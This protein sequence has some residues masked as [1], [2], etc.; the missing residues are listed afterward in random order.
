MLYI[1]YCDVWS[2]SVAEWTGLWRTISKVPDSIPSAGYK[3]IKQTMK[4]SLPCLMLLHR[5]VK[6]TLNPHFIYLIFVMFSH[7][8]AVIAA[9]ILNTFFFFT[10][11]I[12]ADYKSYNPTDYNLNRTKYKNKWIKTHARENIFSLLEVNIA[13]KKLIYMHANWKH[14]M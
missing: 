12:S 6:R 2:I 14:H 3:K 8:L 11:R 9:V 13:W 10:I 5:A 1:C 4:Y 7:Y